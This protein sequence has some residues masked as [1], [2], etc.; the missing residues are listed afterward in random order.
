[1]PENHVLSAADYLR[2][3]EFGRSP[4]EIASLAAGRLPLT[5]Q[6]R[7]FAIQARLARW[8]TIRRRKDRPD[9]ISATVARFPKEYVPETAPRW[10]TVAKNL[11]TP[12]D[13]WRLVGDAPIGGDGGGDAAE[14]ARELPTFPPDFPRL[15][16][17]DIIEYP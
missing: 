9:A 8:R 16:R 14:K 15:R 7:V 10:P 5:L 12:F 2:A 13:T 3:G 4:R 11:P 6:Y 17:R 1:M